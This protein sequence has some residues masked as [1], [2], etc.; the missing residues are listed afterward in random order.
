MAT[1]EYL[2]KRG[3][4]VALI[5]GLAMLAFILQAALESGNFLFSGSKF[6]VARIGDEK[7]GVQDYQ[8]LLAQK[9]ELFKLRYGAEANSYVMQ[10]LHAQTWESLMNEFLYGEAFEEIGIAVHPDELYDLVQGT[11]PHPIVVQEF[12]DPNNPMSFNP[13][14]VRQFLSALNDDETGVRKKFWLDIE[15]RVYYD[16]MR[17][18][19][20]SL[21]GKGLYVTSD[22]AQMYHEDNGHVVDFDYV[23]LPYT[24]IPDADVKVSD[25]EIK[26]WYKQHKK[27]YKQND[28]RDIEFVVFDLLPSEQDIAAIKK[29]IA[30]LVEPFKTAENNEYFVSRNSDA[31]FD[32]N[33]YQKGELSPAIDSLMFSALPGFTYGPYQEGPAFKISKLD[34]VVGIPDSSK[35]RHILIAFDE[36]T[37]SDQAK[38][39]AD[40]IKTALDAG[41]D[42]VELVNKYSDDQGSKTMGGDVGWMT[43]QTSFVKPFLDACMLGKK[44]DKKVVESQYGMHVIE[45]TDQTAVQK[46]VRVATLQLDLDPSKETRNTIYGQ[47]V[48]FAMGHTTKEAF[49]KGAEDN[50][51][52]IRQA[53][54]LFPMSYDLPGVP[55][56]REIVKWAFESELGQVSDAFEVGERYIVAVVVKAKEQGIAP[57]EDVKEEVTADVIREKK[58][59]MLSKEFGK[60]KGK[61]LSEMAA[62]LKVN[63][64]K[65][66][67][68]TFVRAQIPS[69]FEPA[70]V[71]AAVALPKDA[72]S[73]PIEGFLGVYVIQLTSVTPSL[74][75]EDYTNERRQL[76]SI[77]SSWATYRLFRSMIDNAEVKDYRYKFF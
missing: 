14:M 55:E 13:E 32:A 46:K 31:A 72:V 22:E 74:P 2:R 15:D 34:T 38:K 77:F 54:N 1:L 36:N 35:A 68:V 4:L 7:I 30:D 70:V 40:S 41:A 44:G 12:S 67:T 8:Q 63:L 58:V 39:L 75:T 11:Q 23:V 21:V 61:P 49:E 43:Y 71:G 25:D 64:E 3:K 76:S 33:F 60:Y 24:Q 52:I 56:A 65:A 6:Q 37:T 17:S 45:I 18:K 62:G 28:T 42:F 59:E 10:Q 29:K 27:K 9:E 47:A 73:D 66:N 48:D 20:V 53:P 19:L 69:G 5:V 16:R 50:K 26:A 57:L 51:L